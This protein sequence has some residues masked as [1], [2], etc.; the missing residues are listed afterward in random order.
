MLRVILRSSPEFADVDGLACL[1]PEDLSDR[2]LDHR[3]LSATLNGA[4]RTRVQ[5][6]LGERRQVRNA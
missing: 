2:A 5:F 6:L 4:A 3:G 1:L